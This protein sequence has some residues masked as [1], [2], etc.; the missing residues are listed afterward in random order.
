MRRGRRGDWLVY[1]SQWLVTMFYAVVWGYVIVGAGLGL[2]GV[3]L[4]QYLSA[5]VF[6]IGLATLLQSWLGHRFAMVSGP[7]V[8]PS[9]AIVA[10]Y[11]AGGADYALH[12][13]TAQAMAGLAIAVLVLCGVVR[14]VQRLWSPLVLGSMIMMVGIS[15][16]GLGIASMARGG[17]GVDFMVAMVLALGGS[18]LAIHGRGVLA[19]LPPLLIIGLGY[20]AFLAMGRFDVALVA[21]APWLT[22]PRVLPYGLSMPPWDLVLLMLVVNLMAALNFYGNLHGYADVVGE[23]VSPV[24]ERRSFLIFAL[25]ETVLPGLLGAPATVSYGEN[26]GIV[27]LTRVAARAFIIAA[28][29][30]FVGLAF[31][32]PFGAL[33]AAMPDEIAGAVLLGIASTVLGI[34]AH[35]LGAA[36]VFERRE[37]T[38]VGF[39]MFL[40][41]GLYLLPAQAWANM[42]VLVKAIFGNP[43]ISVILFVML[44]EH[45]IFRAR[46]TS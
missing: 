14:Y 36:P 25:A 4:T 10:A 33:M 32:G 35:T 20:L 24:V 9:L 40:S 6:T 13:F 43:V 11:G 39:S 16:A 45:V 2:R 21:Q 31:I 27:Q 12:A 1:G 15:V 23:T 5:I 3:A 22:T 38:L 42:P 44:F 46:P 37:Q 30:V 18:V 41:L 29:A 28:A 17:I 34:G 8:I 26:L 7:N 19:T